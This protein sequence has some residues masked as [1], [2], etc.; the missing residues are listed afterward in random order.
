MPPSLGRRISDGGLWY[1][2]WEEEIT[3]RIKT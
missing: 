2:G 3:G 1:P